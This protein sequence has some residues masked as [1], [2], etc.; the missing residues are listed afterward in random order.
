MH[1]AGLQQGLPFLRSAGKCLTQRLGV[2]QI[3]WNSENIGM[4]IERAK[5]L[6][7]VAYTLPVC[8]G[9]MAQHHQVGIFHLVQIKLTKAFGIIPA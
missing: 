5:I 4:G 3:P 1:M 9:D 6:G 7:T 2:Q 8:T